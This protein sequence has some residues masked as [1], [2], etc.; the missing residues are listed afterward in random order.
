MSVG[1]GTVFS[2]IFIT[3]QTYFEV[4]NI[5]TTDL[6]TFEVK[7]RSACGLIPISPGLSVFFGPPS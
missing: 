3:N 6:Y 7:M 5:D 4:E 1:K 2:E